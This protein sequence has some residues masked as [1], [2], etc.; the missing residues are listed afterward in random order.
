MPLPI[1]PNSARI[2]DTPTKLAA[3]ACKRPRSLA[4]N[5]AH[6]SLRT[7]GLPRDGD[8]SDVDSDWAIQ[9]HGAK[10]QIWIRQ[11]HLRPME[12]WQLLA[13]KLVLVT[14]PPGQLQDHNAMLTTEH[15]VTQVMLRYG[16]P[17]GWFQNGTKRG[18]INVD[19]ARD[20]T[21]HTERTKVAPHQ[22]SPRRHGGRPHGD[23]CSHR[24]DLNSGACA[25]GTACVEIGH[26]SNGQS[27]LY[28]PPNAWSF[29]M[30]ASMAIMWH[31]APYTT[32]SSCVP[33]IA[34]SLH[35]WHKKRNFHWRLPWE[36]LPVAPAVEGLSLRANLTRQPG[37]PARPFV[38][39]AIAPEPPQA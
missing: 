35:A 3:I 38:R 22:G 7:L 30:W 15:V 33:K 26:S 14:A 39:V 20:R 1:S 32:L 21:T 4:L 11:R 17:Q 5:E 16:K 25:R 36:I 31:L 6:K 12:A 29:F 24:S 8:C 27:I 19:E 18:I 37:R 9:G 2:K 28:T 34:Q 23:A 10:E 13:E